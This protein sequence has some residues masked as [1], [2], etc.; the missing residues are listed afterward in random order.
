MSLFLASASS[1]GI[2]NVFSVHRLWSD[3][4]RGRS[5]AATHEA[6]ITSAVPFHLCRQAQ[7]PA[8]ARENPLHASYPSLVPFLL[9]EEECFQSYLPARLKVVNHSVGFQIAL[10]SVF[11]LCFHAVR[12]VGPWPTEPF[13]NTCRLDRLSKGTVDH[14]QLEHYTI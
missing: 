13:K 2:R 12:D 3:L 6:P 10:R 1:H 4:R 5:H 8:A 11:V 9:I 7:P 14:W